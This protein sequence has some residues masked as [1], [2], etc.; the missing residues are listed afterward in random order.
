MTVLLVQLSLQKS[1]HCFILY[2]R[3]SAWAYFPLQRFAFN[4]SLF[5]RDYPVLESE[6]SLWLN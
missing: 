6:M 5:L 4:P 2:L 1:R 3:R